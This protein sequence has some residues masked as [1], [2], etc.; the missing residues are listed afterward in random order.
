MEDK[1]ITSAQIMDAFQNIYKAIPVHYLKYEGIPIAFKSHLSLL[2]IFKIADD[3]SSCCFLDDGEYVP[4][5][6]NFMLKRSITETVTNIEL[7]EDIQECYDF[8]FYTPFGDWLNDIYEDYYSE[9]LNMLKIAIN[10]KIDYLADSGLALLRSRMDGLIAAIEK[11]GEQSL[12]MF[13]DIS[14]EDR[15]KLISSLDALGNISEDKLVKAFLKQEKKS[16]SK[17]STKSKSKA[18][19]APKPTEDK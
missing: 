5:V 18:K 17:S 1:K 14:S 9:D 2:D 7:P 19:S 6:R 16:K 10:D 4:E 13:G 11:L 15:D 12:N 3:V 8:L